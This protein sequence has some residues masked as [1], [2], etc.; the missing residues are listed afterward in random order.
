[1]PA[2]NAKAEK[3]IIRRSGFTADFSDFAIAI[4]L[5]QTASVRHISYK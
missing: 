2:A 5:K 1:M 4:I 3:A